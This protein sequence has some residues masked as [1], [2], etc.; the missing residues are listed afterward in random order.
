M[1]GS[2]WLF[3]IAAVLLLALSAGAVGGAEP[4]PADA[5]G[6][7]SEQ[8]KNLLVNPGFE[9]RK[10]LEGG[11]RSP[12]DAAEGWR[13]YGNPAEYEKGGAKVDVDESVAHRGKQSL[14]LE[15][16][17]APFP[18]TVEQ[19]DVPVE[20]GKEYLVSLWAKGKAA[21]DTAKTLPMR[22]DL[23]CMEVAEGQA[24]KYRQRVE[25]YQVPNEWKKY[26]FRHT[27]PQGTT[28]TNLK[29][30]LRRRDGSSAVGTLWLDDVSCIPV[31]AAQEQQPSGG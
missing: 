26:S 16:S 15:N 27:I 9:S 17:T 28:N 25:V 2:I 12:Y 8:E 29:I 14:K 7:G 30:M 5:E 24:T 1:R 23:W 31:E 13:I 22:L 11:Y 20:P 19:R 6:D 3:S 21:E 10:F 4:A 18:S